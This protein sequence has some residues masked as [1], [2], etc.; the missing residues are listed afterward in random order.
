[1]HPLPQ[2]ALVRVRRLLRPPEEYDGWKVNRRPPRV[3]DVGTIVDVLSSP[4]VEERSY[5]VEFSGSG[6]GDEWLG[7]FRLD[8]LELVADASR[9]EDRALTPKEPEPLFCEIGSQVEF[10]K[11]VAPTHREGELTTTIAVGDR[12]RVARLVGFGWDLQRV[13]G[14]GPMEVRLLNSQMKEY[15]KIA[16]DIL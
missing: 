16:D 14:K 7:D 5:V 9:K 11:A 12:Y 1:M 4:D 13:S 15:V 3:G 6:G 8:E 10:V 2:Y